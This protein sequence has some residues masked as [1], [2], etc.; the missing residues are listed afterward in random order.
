MRS[1]VLYGVSFIFFGASFVAQATP[2]CPTWPP[3]F[4]ELNDQQLEHL[5]RKL[6]Q[7]PEACLAQPE[8]LSLAAWTAAKQKDWFNA[9]ALAE[10]AVLLHPESPARQMDFAFILSLSGNHPEAVLL[11]QALLQRA[12]VP[13]QLRGSLEEWLARDPRSLALANPADLAGPKPEALASGFRQQSRLFF[14]LGHDT[15]L[16][17]GI[18]A[19][20]ITIGI[21]GTD[22]VL[23]VAPS[24]QARQGSLAVSGIGA[25][26]LQLASGQP[27]LAVSLNF[28]AR[29]PLQLSG[30]SSE[31]IDLRAQLFSSALQGLRAYSDFAL[32]KTVGLRLTSTRYGNQPLFHLLGLRASWP[33]AP[34]TSQCQAE[35]TSDIEHRTYPVNRPFDASVLKAGWGV[36]CIGNNQERRFELWGALDHPQ[37]QRPG[38]LSRRLGAQ[39]SILWPLGE[40]RLQAQGLFEHAQDK[41]GYSPL[42][43]SGAARWTSFFVSGVTLSKPVHTNAQWFLRLELR[44]QVSNLPIFESRARTALLGLEVVF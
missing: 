23:P 19:S 17:N 15:N 5:S 26:W 41:E 12:D 28:V 43:A 33:G 9:L 11:V 37:G 22:L 30:F 32:P 18:S 3:N 21:S 42:L 1:Y 2:V 39:A 36:L 31:A 8:F 27:N 34:H 6:S 20:Q 14:A 29:T 24:E 4:H 35:W 7:A 25:D 13:A 38:G 44:R 40:A 16:N 10:R